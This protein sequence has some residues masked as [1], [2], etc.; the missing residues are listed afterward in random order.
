MVQPSFFVFRR[1]H[2]T[3]NLPALAVT[4]LHAFRGLLSSVDAKV[5]RRDAQLRQ[6]SKNE[7]FVKFRPWQSVEVD[8]NSTDN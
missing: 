8:S 1:V 4:F 3:M 6:S 5:T 7:I 2:V